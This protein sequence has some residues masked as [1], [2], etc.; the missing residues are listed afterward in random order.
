MVRPVIQKMSS[1]VRQHI[2]GRDVSAIYLVGG[3][4]CLQGIEKVMEHELGKPVYKP[5]NP[6]LVTPMGIAMNCRA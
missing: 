3:T 6:F 2:Q 5:A 1:I 4:C